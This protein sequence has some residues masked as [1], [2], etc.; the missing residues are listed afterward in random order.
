MRVKIRSS[1][2]R[3]KE[4]SPRLWGHTISVRA[5]LYRGCREDDTAAE[6]RGQFRAVDKNASKIPNKVE[7]IE[8][9]QIKSG[10]RSSG[11]S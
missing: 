8:C 4:Q 5:Y 3:P 7:E 6:I 10:K 2:G 9:L 11:K 1:P